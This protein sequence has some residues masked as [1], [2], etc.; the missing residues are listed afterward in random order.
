ML[1]RNINPSQGLCNGTRLIVTELHEYMIKCKVISNPTQTVYLPRMILGPTS[2]QAGFEFKRRQFPISIAF[3]MTINKSQGQT[4]KHTAIYLPQTCFEHGQLYV[5]V[6][7]VTSPDNLK[8]YLED[9]LF[10][11]NV[12]GEW[13]TMNIVHKS[14]LI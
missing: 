11:G 3:A 2:N 12:D 8:I 14:L 4:M 13:I 5:A 9:S 10:N 7:R 1:L 6:S